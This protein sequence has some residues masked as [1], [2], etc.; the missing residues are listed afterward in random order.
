DFGLIAMLSVF[1][2]VGTSLSD[3]GLTSSLIRT[4]E[5]GQ[6]DYSTVFFMNLTASALIYGA[7]FFTAPLIANFF[8][9]P[10]LVSII[11]IYTCT[12]IIRAFSQVQQTKLTKE[13][14][15]TLQM[16]I[17][18]PSVIIAGVA[19]VIM[20]YRGMGVWSLVY[21]NIIQTSLSAIQLWFRTRWWPSIEFDWQ[22][23]KKHLNVV[24]KL[25]LAGIL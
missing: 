15:F 14:N 21:M 13:M 23:L 11:R 7:L 16:L 19:G 5:A 22:L 17:Q 8:D 12:F 10:L 2:A 18:I 1:I 3:S 6:R 4:K 25:T 20:A 9:Q 24:Y